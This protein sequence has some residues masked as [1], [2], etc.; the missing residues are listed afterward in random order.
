MANC[1]SAINCWSI[2]IRC[3]WVS[4]ICAT[5][6]VSG[7]F[8]STKTEK[9]EVFFTFYLF[10][11]EFENEWGLLVWCGMWWSWL[12]CVK[13]EWHEVSG[14]TAG[15]SADRDTQSGYVVSKVW[16]LH[17]IFSTIFVCQFSWWPMYVVRCIPVI[18]YCL[19]ICYNMIGV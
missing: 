11:N 10:V 6:T 19:L 17:A 15:R 4:E 7:C 18:C 13:R 2:R 5:L 9:V 16:L 14:L 12:W 1:A 3:D 8:F